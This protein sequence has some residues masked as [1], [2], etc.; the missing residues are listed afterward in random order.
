[1][2]PLC[3]R[4]LLLWAG[5]FQFN[6]EEL[7]SSA[8]GGWSD[9]RPGLALADVAL[10]CLV[11]LLLA[12]GAYFHG[13]RVA[14][15]CAAIISLLCTI[16]LGTKLVFVFIEGE[17]SLLYTM[18]VVTCVIS[19]VF[20]TSTGC[21]LLYEAGL[22]TLS[23]F[24]LVRYIYSSL[25][26]AAAAVIVT[27][28]IARGDSVLPG[29]P[30][31]IVSVLVSAVS[32]LWHLEGVQVAILGVEGAALETFQTGSRAQRLQRL[33]NKPRGVKRFLIGRQFL[34]I[35]VVYLT[36]QV[37]TFPEIELPLPQ[38][39]IA[40][41]VDT[42]LPGV[43]LVLAIGQLMP[44]LMAASD[45]R[46]FMNLPGCLPAVHLCLGLEWVGIT[47]FSWLCS[48]VA[49]RLAGLDGDSS[50]NLADE[51]GDV[52]RTGAFPYNP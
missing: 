21:A 38:L 50:T 43:L 28:G 32:V 18:R 4:R 29:S 20:S 14:S 22:C 47:H 42:G 12:A 1:M 34:V 5:A 39:V 11:R 51:A 31:I 16:L 27:I 48:H 44:Q 46:W 36:A 17:N 24:D 3:A 52:A 40:I 25:L 45:P 26:T 49:N 15:I 13:S 19:V 30:L 37:T 10:A 35:F 23:V 8:D 41:I 9:F 33:M 6:L 2:R 7:F